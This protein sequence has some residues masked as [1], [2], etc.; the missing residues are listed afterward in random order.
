MPSS[1]KS[2]Q[3]LSVGQLAERWKVS[4]ERVRGLINSGLIPEAFQIPSAGR[5][6]TTLKIP[7]TVVKQLEADWA[8]RST[9][10]KKRRS[11]KPVPELKHLAGLMT[12]PECDAGC[13]G[14]DHD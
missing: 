3:V 10:R 1:E 14:D 9:E 5:F 12:D 6:G 2:P 4:P 13:P 7:W 11:A 8:V